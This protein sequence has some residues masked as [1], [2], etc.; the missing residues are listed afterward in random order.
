MK[1][2]IIIALICMLPLYACSQENIGKFIDAFQM[3][4][5]YS[6]KDP[7]NYNINVK[8]GKRWGVFN[9]FDGKGVIAGVSFR[10]TKK[11][12][13][14]ISTGVGFNEKENPKLIDY[15]LNYGYNYQIGIQYDIYLPH[16]FVIGL[17]TYYN[18]FMGVGL[19]VSLGLGYK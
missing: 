8:W 19:G 6:K 7:F 12:P 2:I 15:N 9:S 5:S 13:L 3:G 10:H 1:K 17:E 11:I 18:H 4:Y 16:N 14:Y